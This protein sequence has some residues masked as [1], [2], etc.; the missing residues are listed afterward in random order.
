MKQKLYTVKLNR[1]QLNTLRF[2][3]RMARERSEEIYKDLEHGPSLLAA[4]LGDIE[5]AE[6]PLLPLYE[7][8]HLTNKGTTADRQV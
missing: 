7:Q 8:A 4:T 6:A 3:L 2:W 5:E 1:V